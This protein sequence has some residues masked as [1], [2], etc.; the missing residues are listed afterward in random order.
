MVI[1]F[2]VSYF[3]TVQIYCSPF[4]HLCSILNMFYLVKYNNTRTKK[5]YS[6]SND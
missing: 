5:Q 4:A 6:I 3:R 1:D 2:I